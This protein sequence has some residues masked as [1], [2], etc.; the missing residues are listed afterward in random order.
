MLSGFNSDQVRRDNI[1]LSH[2]L[3]SMT[4][5]RD[6]SV[7]RKGAICFDHTVIYAAPSQHQMLRVLRVDDMSPD[8]IFCDDELLIFFAETNNLF[9]L[10]N[11]PR[12]LHD[13][14]TGL[15]K[16]FL[17]S[18]LKQAL[19]EKILDAQ[20]E[21]CYHLR[22]EIEYFQDKETQLLQDWPLEGPGA[23][24]RKFI[25]LVLPLLQTYPAEVC[26]DAIGIVSIDNPK[27]QS[28]HH[29]VSILPHCVMFDFRESINTASP[30]FI[31]WEK[32]GSLPQLGISFMLMKPQEV[33][34]PERF[35]SIAHACAE[36][37][38]TQEL[39]GKT[40]SMLDSSETVTDKE[41]ADYAESEQGQGEQGQGEQGWVIITT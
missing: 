5:W 21:I 17:A 13:V 16:C 8:I 33:P 27:Y 23:F 36:G 25:S 34:L 22:K 3:N 32:L 29:I 18:P 31:K 20:K 39:H 19:C 9:P 41:A 38:I 15:Q 2:V 26:A 7:S 24:A 28:S 11:I 14:A 10:Q 37:P 12:S 4:E 30:L 1:F 6:A 40:E 35:G